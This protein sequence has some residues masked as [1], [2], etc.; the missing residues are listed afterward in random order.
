MWR[1]VTS[2]ICGVG[3]ALVLCGFVPTWTQ[4]QSS[5]SDSRLK[6]VATVPELGSLVRDIGGD[7][8]DVTVFAK[9]TE[10]AHFVEAKPSFVKILSRADVF[11]QIGMGMEEGWVPT[12][13]QQARNRRIVQGA[14]GYMN[15]STVIA[16]LQ[17]ASG[18]VDRSMGDIHP[19]GNPHYLLDPV[20][21]LQ[22]A[23]LIRDR[24]SAL[25]PSHRANFEVRYTT[26]YHHVGSGLMGESLAAKYDVAKLAL[27]ADHDKL[28][29]FLASQGELASLGG[30]LGQMRAYR[31]VSV[32]VDHNQWVY[33][34]QRFGLD[35]AGSMEPKPGLPPTTQH[36]HRLIK[37]MRAQGV[38]LILLGAY[39]D[40]RHAQFLAK[41]TGAKIVQMAHQVGARPEA[42][43]Y[44]HMIDYNIQQIQLALTPPK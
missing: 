13:L 38:K 8:V 7:D 28:D 30:W 10:D 4:A 41:H 35:I 29:A 37:T 33:F 22:V 17:A 25:R 16:P 2:M 34:T 32:V 39:F 21:G 18:A 27:L 42:V 14:P 9:G 23:Q 5:S 40:P 11:I 24:L 44:V 12:L 6:V 15:A 26:F 20:R 43:D 31:G 19:E 3:L 36:L 1:Y